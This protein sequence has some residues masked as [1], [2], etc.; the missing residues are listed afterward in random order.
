MNGQLSEHPFGELIR[1]ISSKK[2]S[3]RLRLQNERVVV[4]TYFENG[5]FL[6]AAANVRN[7]RLGE[8]LLKK[9]LVAEEQLHQ[10]GDRK[11]DLQLA[12][13]LASENLVDAN[14]VKS[15]QLRQQVDTLRLALLWTEG[16]W[17]FDHRSHLNEKVDLKLNVQDLFLEAGRRLPLQFTGSRF[18]NEHEV[19][20]LNENATNANRLE[21]RE[22]F[23]LSRLDRPTQL[24]ELLALSG[25]RAEDALRIIYSL[26]LAGY[27]TREHWKSAFRDEIPSRQTPET[28]IVA[29]EIHRPVAE[30]Q[31]LNLADFLAR[32]EAATTHYEVLV[33]SDDASTTEIKHAYYDIAR[34]YHPDR[35]RRDHDAS[36]HARVEALFARITQAYETLGDTGHRAAYDSKLAAR[37]NITH[38]APPPKAEIPVP[39][40]VNPQI[41][42]TPN[43]DQ[44]E[45]ELQFK[46]GL[47]ALQRGQMNQAAAL[48]ASVAKVV[49]NDARYRAFHGRALAAN[50]KTR[51]MAESELREALK[52]DPD[53]PDY[54]TMLAELYR[55]LGFAKRARA[56]AERALAA[57]PGHQGARKLLADLK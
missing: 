3:G 41:V 51:R 43:N 36:L 2:L 48:F 24:R 35:F 15:L 22:G 17:D 56:E 39:S 45:V 27:V 8:Y 40:T 14:T 32:V 21:P 5:A 54:R 30:N 29:E 9:N 23:M 10:I 11:S 34:R 19:I 18:R 42:S 44:V 33:V 55:D 6:Y 28:E 31:E 13:A 26:A 25:L 12:A 16:T 57:A 46:E 37:K 38:P 50:E 52:L 49:P 20:S 1:E 7:L 47:A 4:V 53:N